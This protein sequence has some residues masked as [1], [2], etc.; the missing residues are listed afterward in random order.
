M[1]R[2]L[3]AIAFAVALPAGAQDEPAGLAAISAKAGHE[4]M[5]CATT[6]PDRQLCTWRDA[7]TFRL[8]C[9]LD[10]AGQRTA[11]PCQRRPDNELM[12]TYPNSTTG[13][14][15][16]AKAAA[17]ERLRS[18]AK[19]QLD[20]ARSLEQ[21]VQ[22]V[23]VGP[24]WCRSDGAAMTCSWHAVRRTPGYVELS[25]IADAPRKKLNLHCVLAADGASRADDSCTMSV[26]GRPE[27]PPS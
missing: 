8:V 5:Y 17:R 13:Q 21:L 11:T 26:G 19:A 22:F 7:D 24:V 16:R 27:P 4:P 1:K 9:E 18:D 20:A 15:T 23:G 25:R 12:W 6:T 10:A 3:A 14:P 2:A